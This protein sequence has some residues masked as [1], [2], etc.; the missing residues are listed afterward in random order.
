MTASNRRAQGTAVRRSAGVRYADRG[1]W[2]GNDWYARYRA[3]ADTL[4]AAIAD[5]PDDMTIAMH[6]CRGNF[7]SS[8]AAS[9]GYDP[10]ADADEISALTETESLARRGEVSSRRKKGRKI[11]IARRK[12]QLNKAIKL[13]NWENVVFLTDD[14]SIIYSE[15][16]SKGLSDYR[17]SFGLYLFPVG[18]M[19]TFM[20]NS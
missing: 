7:R 9:G 19:S 5:R 16:M 2:F 10:A 4:E 1:N 17:V 14:L 12:R 8:H 20:L 13:G 3:Y 15:D 6:L 11:V 18:A